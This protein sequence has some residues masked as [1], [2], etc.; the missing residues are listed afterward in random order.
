MKEKVF[1]SVYNNIYKLRHL[2]LS[3]RALLTYNL[4]NHRPVARNTTNLYLTEIKHGPT[5]T[6]EIYKK[7]SLISAKT[8]LSTS[9]HKKILD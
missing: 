8:S 1:K 9:K 4:F 5:K 3:S 6:K 2:R 7:V